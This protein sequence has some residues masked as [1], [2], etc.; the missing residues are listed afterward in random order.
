M[1]PEA[2]VYCLTYFVVDWLPV[3]VSQARCQIVTESLTL[4]H[5]AKHL[6]INAYGIMPTRAT[7]P[8]C[9]SDPGGTL[10]AAKAGLPA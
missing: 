3:F 9:R 1:H 8:P 4:C 5:D 10:L 7:G 2:A 6:R